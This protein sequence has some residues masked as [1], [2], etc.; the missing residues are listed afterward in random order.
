MGN[1]SQLLLCGPHN[2]TTKTWLRHSEERKLQANIFQE[3]RQENTGSKQILLYMKR[4]IHHDHVGFIPGM[5]HWFKIWESISVIYYINRIKEKNN[6]IISINAEENIWQDPTPIHYKMLGL[7]FYLK[8]KQQ[9]T[10]D[11]KILL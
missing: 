5:Q 1:T 6:M 8:K 10:R 4:I 9:P 3:H 2:H 11:R 7:A